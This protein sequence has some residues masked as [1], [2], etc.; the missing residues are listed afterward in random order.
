MEK[1][2]IKESLFNIRTIGCCLTLLWVI[3]LPTGSVKAQSLARIFGKVVDTA[4]LPIEAANIMVLDM[5]H[6]GT[7]TNEFGRYDLVVPHDKEMTVEVSCV[8]YKTEKQTI[9]LAAGNRK[10]LNFELIQLAI[11]LP[12]FDVSERYSFDDGME[13]ISPKMVYHIPGVTAGVESLIKSAGMGVFSNNE[14]SSQ[15][16]VRGGNYDENLIYLN[17]IEIYRPFLIRSGQQEGLSFINPDL[18][19]SVKFSSGGFDASYGDKMSSVLD[20]QYK[21]PTRFA[22]SVSGS[23]LGASGHLEGISN[24]RKFTALVGLRY[25][26]NGYMFKQLETKGSYKPTFT[27]GQFLLTYTPS[28][29]WKFILFGNY[30]RNIYRLIPDTSV[31]RM[32][33][34]NDVKEIK[35][36]YTGQEVDAYQTIYTA[37]VAKYLAKEHTDLRFSLSYFNSEEKETFDLE[38]Q[39]FINEVSLGDDS[40]GDVISSSDV[41]KEFHHARNFFSSHLFHGEFQGE[42]RLKANVLNWGLKGQGEIMDDKL[43]EWR[44]HDSAGYT[45]PHYPTLPG[46]LVPFDDSSRIIS[47]GNTYLKTNNR[48]KTFRLS[49][50]VQDKWSF[51]TSQHPFFLIGGIRFSYWTWNNEFILTPRLRLMYQPKLKA[52]ISFYLAT[53]MYFQP[54]FYKEMRLPD[55]TL[56]KNIKSQQSYHVILGMDYLFKIERRPFK[57]ST[58][59]YYKYLQHLIT[60]TMDNVRVIYSGDNDAVGYAVGVDA[61]LSGE[62]VHNLESWLAVSLMKSAESINGDTLT[63]RPMDQRFALNLFF[64][65]RVPKLP[66][67]KAH[68][69]LIYSTPLP[70]SPPTVRRYMRSKYS[71]FRTDIGFSWQFIDAVTRLGKKNPFRFLNAGYLT[72]EVANVF[73]YKNVL[74]YSWVSNMEGAYYVIPNYLTPRLFNVKLRFEF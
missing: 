35:V 17:G 57:F 49:G 61:K 69:V 22:G 30:T 60:Y 72:L 19:S 25:Q 14:M 66:M 24:D 48:L 18:V 54:S 37:F 62:I 51:G 41:G 71:Y 21:Q 46:D 12:S 26:S 38:A 68:I 47:M 10:Q 29:K 32:G 70:Y 42:H 15:Y 58:E 36:F 33:T 59:L 52:D 44:I 31:S 9:Q 63:P 50:F 67:L 74:S 16:T 6:A 45:L 8:G 7:W 11:T 27:D 39:Y 28:P 64:Q 65:D 3:V 73:N 13:R 23:L 5:D 34:M 56:N 2:V 55:G 20:V 1:L 40:Y 43:S 53:G 4:G